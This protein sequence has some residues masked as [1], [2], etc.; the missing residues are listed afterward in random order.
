MKPSQKKRSQSVLG[1]SLANGQLRAFHMTRAKGGAEVVKSARATLSLDILHPEPE[2]IGR[3][4]KNHL[5]A[6][7]I[8]ERHCIVA[9]PAR[10]V[11]SQHSKVPELSASDTTSFLQLEAEKGF[12][13]DPA[14]LQI[15]RSFQR[16]AD[17][18]SVTQLAVRKEQIDQLAAVLK[19]AGLKPV[20]F[21]PGLAMLPGAVPPAGSG[22]ITVAVEP[23]GVTLL[24]AAGGGIAAF[25]TCEASIESEAGEKLANGAAVAREL[26]IT[27]EQVPPALRSEVRQLFITGESTMAR[28]LAESLGDWAKAA[29]LTIARGDLPEKDFASE[30]AEKLAAHWLE[31]GAVEL[32]F[33]PPRPSRWASM[34]ARYSSKRLATAGFA[35]GAAAVLALLAFGWQEFRLVSLRSEWSGMEAQVTA[36]DA[37]QARIREFRPW[38]DT[39]F[40]TLSI[41]K[42]VTE[43]FPDSGVVTAKTIEFRGNS[44]VTITGTTRDNAALLRVHDQLRQAKEVQSP[45][46]EQIRGKTPM[47]FTITFRWNP[48]PG[49]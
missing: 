24:V 43:C 48:V 28:Q 29:G 22:R 44:I 27:F 11:M 13:V 46:L 37:V 30:L 31:N 45:K 3:E 40:R 26:R 10:W 15:A 9:V 14:Q 25:R 33:L 42:R 38:Y 8:R 5:D 32:E 49:T 17:G 2:L 41:L 20:S 4:I 34:M 12:P 19:A 1:L 35:V 47:Q 23:S 21:A 39:S 7:G 16:S 36:L 6:A 18:T